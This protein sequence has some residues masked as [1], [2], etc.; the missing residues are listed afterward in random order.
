M[1]LSPWTDCIEGSVVEEMGTLA[2]PN[3]QLPAENP[4]VTFT[5]SLM[6]S[7]ILHLLIVRDRQANI[8]GPAK[9]PVL[10]TPPDIPV[11]NH[12]ASS[13]VVLEGC[14]ECVVDLLPAGTTLGLSVSILV[15]LPVGSGSAS[16]FSGVVIQTQLH[17]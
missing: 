3:N 14:G 8:S 4:P 5:L 15:R 13:G 2:V 12:D 16:R 6:V 7:A 1:G 10:V 11:P 9:V 17:C